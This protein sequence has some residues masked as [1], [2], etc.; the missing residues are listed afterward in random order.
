M[1]RRSALLPMKNIMTYNCRIVYLLFIV[2]VLSGCA[3]DSGKLVVHSQTSVEI[4]LISYD[5]LTEIPIFVGDVV[6]GSGQEIQT[7]YRGLALLGFAGGQ[8]YPVIIGDEP[9]I[10]NIGGPGEPPAFEGNGENDFLYKKLSGDDSTLGQ[11]GFALLMI[12][13]KD[14]LKSTHSIRN[15]EE[16]T[17]KKE[18]FHEFVRKN[19]ENLRHSDMIRQLIAQYFMMHEYVDYHKQGA[20][21]T[22][23]RIQYQ[24]EVVSGVGSWLETLKPHLQQQEVLNYIVSLYYNR[25]MVTLASLIIDNFR[26]VAYCPGDNKKIFSF[27]ADMHIAVVDGDKEGKLGDFKGTKI[28]AFVSEDCPVSMVETVN[29][30][31]QLANQKENVPV[32][33]APLQKLSRNHLSMASMIRHKNMFFINDEQ[34]RKENLPKKIQLPLFIRIGDS[35]D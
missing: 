20:P 3:T 34:W 17:A 10:L 12:Q 28:I 30:A 5:G 18:E 23:I 15:A 4:D 21:A 16:L 9:L 24:K 11:Y 1:K 13:A 8:R 14:L 27:S 31:R 22:D 19:Y 32:I 7:S 6:P 2:V 33:V 29:K 35:F 26:D 25:S